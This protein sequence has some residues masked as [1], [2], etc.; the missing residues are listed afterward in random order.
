MAIRKRQQIVVAISV[1]DTALLRPIL[2]FAPKRRDTSTEE[3]MLQPKA[4]AMK[5]SVIS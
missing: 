5:I 4:K 3:P 1:V 2:S